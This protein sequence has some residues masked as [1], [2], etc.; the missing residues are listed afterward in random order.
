MVVA[1]ICIPLIAG[2]LV[3]I[4]S[5][6]SNA[7]EMDTVHHQRRPCM[8]RGFEADQR[9]QPVTRRW[10]SWVADNLAPPLDRK[11]L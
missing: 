11:A 5:T 7:E 4:G 10:K 8:D 2:I 6:S 3:V 9:R 1:R